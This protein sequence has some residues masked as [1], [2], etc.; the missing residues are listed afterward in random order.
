MTSTLRTA[1][2][3]LVGLPNQQTALRCLTGAGC[4]FPE[5]L[6]QTIPPVISFHCSFAVVRTRVPYKP[7]VVRSAALILACLHRQGSSQHWPSFSPTSTPGSHWGSAPGT[8]P[9]N[10]MAKVQKRL[11]A[12]VIICWVLHRKQPC[13]TAAAIKSCKLQ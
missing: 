5:F 6:P 8:C 1:R 10:C 2:L 4:L 3:F 13:I 12:K 9:T 7:C 11:L